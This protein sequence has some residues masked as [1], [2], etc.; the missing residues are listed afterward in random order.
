MIG[1]PSVGIV[2]SAVLAERSGPVVTAPPSIARGRP[3]SGT[4]ELHSADPLTGGRRAPESS[5]PCDG[6][7]TGT[8]FRLSMPKSLFGMMRS[9]SVHRRPRR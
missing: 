9:H 5:T 1:T 4:V 7:G 3:P 8:A 6:H 2:T